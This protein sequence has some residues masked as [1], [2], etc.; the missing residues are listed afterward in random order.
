MEWKFLEK[1]FHAMEILEHH[2]PSDG[3]FGENAINP[4]AP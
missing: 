2:F 3:N 4:S 1:F